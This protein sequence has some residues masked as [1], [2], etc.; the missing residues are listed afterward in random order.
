MGLSMMRRLNLMSLPLVLM[1]FFFVVFLQ[2]HSAR[3]LFPIACLHV[4]WCTRSARPSAAVTAA[5]QPTLFQPV[6]FK[7]LQNGR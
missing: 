6:D 5:S 1:F 2:A 7:K 3:T 4:R